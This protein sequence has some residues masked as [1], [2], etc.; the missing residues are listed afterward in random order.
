[1][2]ATATAMT[3]SAETI[4]SLAPQLPFATPAIDEQKAQKKQ[5]PL[6]KKAKRVAAAAKALATKAQKKA[7][8]TATG[9]DDTASVHPGDE[10][11]GSSRAPSP[12][13]KAKTPAPSR[14]LSPAPARV[15]TPPNPLTYDDDHSMVAPDVLT[16]VVTETAAEKVP[17][18]EAKTAPVTPLPVSDTASSL[19]NS[20]ATT[21]A[22]ATAPMELA[23]AE[24]PSAEPGVHHE[25][26]RQMLVINGLIKLSDALAGKP[27][28][29]PARP[30][31]GGKS[32]ARFNAMTADH[33]K[34]DGLMDRFVN[35]TVGCTCKDD[36]TLETICAA[37]RALR[38]ELLAVREKV[39]ADMGCELKDAKLPYCYRCETVIEDAGDLNDLDGC[40]TC[41]HRPMCYHFGLEN[42]Y[43]STGMN[44]NVKAHMYE[45][46]QKHESGLGY[47]GQ[48][49]DDLQNARLRTAKKHGGS[50]AALV[51]VR[52][53]V[54]GMWLGQA[55]D[56]CDDETLE[57]FA[58]ELKTATELRT[59]TKNANPT[60]KQAGDKRPRTESESPSSQEAVKPPAAKK[61]KTKASE[62]DTDS[63]V[64][65]AKPKQAK[66]Q[67]A[68][69]AVKPKPKA[70]AKDL[71]VKPKAKDSDSDS[72][73]V[74]V[75]IFKAMRKEFK[76]KLA[77]KNAELAAAEKRC[78]KL[79][80]L[81]ESSKKMAA[82]MVSPNGNGAAN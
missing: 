24:A 25:L 64:E 46:V 71:P 15:M 36:A 37:C 72:D 19:T 22:V 55:L 6:S 26:S 74:D 5:K 54:K 42:R 70:K 41:N 58:D 45:H 11:V 52:N 61:A 13:P 31:T 44:W 27:A 4:L 8:A 34:R 23:P 59:A 62:S 30:S 67:S 65:Q 10:D 20:I 7:K 33:K 28:E 80:Q 47:C 9:D 78:R 32:V 81:S 39:K 18:S 38:G 56:T 75:A 57:A 48:C 73:D 60:K 17:L 21:I 1:M 69:E 82:V 14:D 40:V 29:A 79:I 12:A 68:T 50:S 63:D 43:K 76:A 16:I 66:A 3:A 77:A 51:K 35:P 2:S 53:Q 49:L